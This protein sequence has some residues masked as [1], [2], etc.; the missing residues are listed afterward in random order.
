MKPA[1]LL[2]LLTLLIGVP[3]GAQDPDPHEGQP[4]YCTNHG[5][6]PAYP[7]KEG[8]ICEC[9][10]PCT[11]GQP[12]DRKCLKWCHKDDCHCISECD[13]QPEPEKEK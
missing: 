8:H 13:N 5:G 11:E 3:S 1:V 4:T 6:H 10:K 7:M 12:E 2:F 9:D